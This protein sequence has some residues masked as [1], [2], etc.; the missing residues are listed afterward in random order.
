MIKVTEIETMGFEHALR[1]MRNPMKSWAKSD[2]YY[3]EDGNYVLG[4]NDLSGI[5][6]QNIDQTVEHMKT[7]NI[8]FS[9][10]YIIRVLKIKTNGLI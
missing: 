4:E 2:S 1:G 10:H 6:L 3:D 9:E 7:S 8:C 5:C